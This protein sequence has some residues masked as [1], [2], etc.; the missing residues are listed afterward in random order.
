MLPCF[1][2]FLPPLVL[3]RPLHSIGAERG[4]RDTLSAA[5]CPSLLPPNITQSSRQSTSP[6]PSSLMVMTACAP[7]A[8][9]PLRQ[10]ASRLNRVR[11]GTTGLLPPTHRAMRSVSSA[12]AVTPSTIGVTC[13][14]FAPTSPA[15]CDTAI[16]AANDDGRACAVAHTS[17]AGPGPPSAPLRSRPAQSYHQLSACDGNLFSMEGSRSSPRPTLLIA[18]SSATFRATI[19]AVIAAGQ[20]HG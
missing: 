5:C 2:F 3:S 17:S 7:A 14:V 10:T 9:P 16:S 11:I 18:T 4:G 13:Y 20:H 6:R 8:A 12:N 1:F 15:A 19:S